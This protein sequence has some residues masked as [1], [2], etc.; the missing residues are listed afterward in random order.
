MQGVETTFRDH[1]DLQRIN[2]NYSYKGGTHKKDIF[3]K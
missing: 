1:Q 2:V 3:E